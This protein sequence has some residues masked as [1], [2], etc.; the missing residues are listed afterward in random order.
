M[1]K[2]MKL[3]LNG[4]PQEKLYLKKYYELEY[5]GMKAKYRMTEWWKNDK[6]S[7]IKSYV[8]H[9]PKELI[10]S[11][12]Y[13]DEVLGINS[14]VLLNFRKIEIIL[15]GIASLFI[16]FKRKF[17]KEWCFLMAIYLSQIA[18]YAYT[19]LPIGKAVSSNVTFG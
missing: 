13:W 7:M 4:D 14:A 10:Y 2:E 5:D 19:A 11:S 1:S 8:F 9:K 18:L 6:L 3:Y 16:V 12:F 17:I 15:F